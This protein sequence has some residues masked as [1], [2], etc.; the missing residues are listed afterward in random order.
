MSTDKTLVLITGGNINS[1]RHQQTTSLT[2]PKANSGIGLEWASQLMAKGPYHILIGARSTSKGQAAV[3]ELQ[4]KGHKGTCELLQID[5]TDDASIAAAA[6]SVEATHGRLDI[7]INNAAIASEEMTRENMISNLN[8]NATGVYFVTQTF[9]PLLLKARG[10]ARVI[11]VSS[12]M[13]SVGLKLDHS[14][15]VSSVAALPYRVSKAALHMVTAELIY[16]FKDEANVKFFTVCPGFTVSNLGPNNKLENGAKAT[17]EAVKPL[18]RI[19]EGKR[20]GEA[21]GFLHADGQYP[22]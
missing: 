9:R 2:S 5:Q 21:N 14:H 3:E 20:D 19:V 1:D 4:S 22:W 17:D 16:E 7:L 10:T 18:L 11:N 15:W 13:G 6:R 8:T 12:G